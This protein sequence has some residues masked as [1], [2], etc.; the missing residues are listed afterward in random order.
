MRISI[1][2]LVF[3]LFAC[4][5]LGQDAKDVYAVEYV[6]PFKGKPAR[7]DDFA[8]IGPDA[9][10]C[11][12]YEPEGMRIALP[13]GFAGDRP[14][15]GVVTTFGIKGD[16]EI[17]VGYEILHE[18]AQA[19]AGSQT[20]FAITVSLDKPFP[21]QN[22]VAFNRRVTNNGPNYYTWM[23]RRDPADN[24]PVL[25]R[26]SFP[27]EVKSGR[28]RLVRSGAVVS[29]LVAE[30]RDKEFT[31]LR[32]ENFGSE[33]VRDINLAGATGGDKAALEVRLTDLRIRA[34]ALT[35]PG[36]VK[37]V[38]LAPPAKEYAHTYFHPFK[39]GPGIY[40]GW[41][42]A[43]PG[44]EQI[45]QF[46][47]KGLHITLPQGWQGDRPATGIRSLFGVKGDFEITMSFALLPEPRQEQAGN[48]NSTRLNLTVTK[49]GPK[50]NVA[51][52]SRSMSPTNG[53]RFGSWS[54]LWNEAVGNQKVESNSTPTAALSG[55]LRLV[56]SGAEVYYGASEGAEGEFAYFKRSL[57]G[58]EDIRN[59]R[60]VTST[61]GEKAA[62]DVR[63]T[64]LRIRA[65]EIPNM[66]DVPVAAKVEQG[67]DAPAPARKGWVAAGLLL[68]LGL[69]VLVGLTL[70]LWL[71][72]QRR[73]SP[74]PASAAKKANAPSAAKR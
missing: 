42:L 13:A 64:D 25:R 51:T 9:D 61:G 26:Q 37:Q 14:S 53:Q 17:T 19:E 52:V 48:A 41:A 63:I 54:S 66:P 69:L 45:V 44:A 2:I 43:G 72:L 58:L 29:F 56:R 4:R 16:F 31:L 22:R 39:A 15:T 8:R 21:A 38:T 74:V 71:Y 34:A 32:K 60:I 49:E 20:R 27:T 46:E 5:A 40:P 28:L 57:F 33:D 24:K 30:G 3:A 23:S 68:A 50:F 55:R 70:G 7:E 35:K 36:P 47:A 62:L 11:V 65:D 10:P 67:E 73:N 12:K 1:S 6:E 18:P 59:V